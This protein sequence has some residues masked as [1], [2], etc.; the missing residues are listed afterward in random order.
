[1][2]VFA[3]VCI[4]CLLIMYGG[5]AFSRQVLPDTITRVKNS[6]VA[7]GTYQANRQPRGVFL[8]TGF[9][10]LDGSLIVTNAHVVPEKLNV[11]N[12]QLLAVFVRINGQEKMVRAELIKQDQRHDLALLKLE[13]YK[14]SPLVLGQTNQV[15]EGQ[16]YAFTGYPIG[17]ILGLY[18]VTHRGIISAITPIAIPM[19][20][21]HSLNNKLLK[22]LSD[23][24]SVFQLDATAY[25]GNSG[26]PL[27]HPGSGQVI[28]VI[29]KVFVKQTKEKV[30]SDPSGITYAIPVDYV[31][32]LLRISGY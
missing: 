17:M 8:G 2:R 25:P 19:H 24:Y 7:V 27:Y 21:S 28:G 22:R 4:A 32:N 29:N 20:N 31:H 1:M 5:I 9:A 6:V 15:R 14:F 11:G 10:V 26:S 16:L 18:P 13:G 3:E 30:L 12:R 23:P